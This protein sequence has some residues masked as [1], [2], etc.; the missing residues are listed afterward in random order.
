VPFAFCQGWNQGSYRVQSRR[1]HAQAPT[2]PPN[3][4]IEVGGHCA[5]RGSLGK[6]FG[7]KRR[8]HSRL[9]ACIRFRPPHSPVG[10]SGIGLADSA[11]TPALNAA[12]CSTPARDGE[13]ILNRFFA[14]LACPFRSGF[15]VVGAPAAKCATIRG[16]PPVGRRITILQREIA[17]GGPIFDFGGGRFGRPESWGVRPP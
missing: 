9:I 10:T 2:L 7:Q 14:G 3:F 16:V 15:Y 12:F 17:L 4:C 5:R 11:L 13:T 6:G 1:C 8:E